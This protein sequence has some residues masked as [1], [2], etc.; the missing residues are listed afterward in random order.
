MAFLTADVIARAR[1]AFSGD[2]AEELL[3][4]YVSALP[5][6]SVRGS[7]VYHGAKG[8]GLV[9]ELRSDVCNRYACAD[10]EALPKAN[11]TLVLIAQSHGTPF[12]VRLVTEHGRAFIARPEQD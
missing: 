6:R 11:G 4:R 3:G 8:C 7:C 9:R 1:A 2:T 10:L 12:D 5:K